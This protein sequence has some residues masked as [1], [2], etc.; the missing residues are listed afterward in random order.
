[1]GDAEEIEACTLSS[2][3]TKQFY[4]KRWRLLLGLDIWNNLGR[5]DEAANMKT[6][7][8]LWHENT[9]ALC[10][11]NE[12]DKRTKTTVRMMINVQEIQRI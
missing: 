3:N 12:L 11:N 7:N 10:Y 9:E 1:M 4:S 2:W 8:Y 6:A 5:P